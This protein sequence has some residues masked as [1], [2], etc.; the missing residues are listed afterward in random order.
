MSE[1]SRPVALDTI[2]DAPHEM[3]IEADAGERAALARRFGWL[4]LDRLAARVTL[5]A[6][7][8]GVDAEG[9][10]AAALT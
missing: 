10:V 5:I 9:T 4:A 8:A 2:G 1:F 6:R 3:A 7:A